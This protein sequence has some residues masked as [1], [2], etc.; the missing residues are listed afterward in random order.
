LLARLAF[1][2]VPVIELPRQPTLRFLVVGDAGATHS[3]LR[4]GMLAVMKE[5]PIDGIL[6]TGDNFYP[7]GVSG[8]SD[9]QWTKITEHFGPT[10]LPIY[11]VLGNHDYG[12]QQE[13]ARSA[14]STCGHPD[15]G[16]EIA[17]DGVVKDWHFPAR[18]YRLHSPLAD[19]VMIDRQPL[20]LG[21]TKPIAGSFSAKEEEAWIAAVLGKKTEAPWRIVVGH[22]TIYS[23]GVH[24]RTNDRTQTRVR[25]LLPLFRGAQVD[26]YICGHDHDLELLARRGG[27]PLFLVSGAGSGTGE[28]RPRKVKGEPLTLYPTF[29]AKA[30]IGFAV[31]ELDARRLSITFYDAK[32]RPTGGPYVTTK[33]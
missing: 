24:G 26:L 30:T 20:A 5:K 8:L 16:S 4:A 29:P 18:N 33:R 27:E 23:S 17:A 11:P 1:A 25:A 7:C 22:H 3:Q 9:P 31:L 13:H 14:Y 28:L 32:G 21:F 19:L 12:D 15:P 10:H 2:A 6:L